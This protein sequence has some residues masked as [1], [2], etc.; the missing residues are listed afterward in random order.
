MDSTSFFENDENI[1]QYPVLINK[2]HVKPTGNGILDNLTF[3]VKD[4]I[5]IKNLPIF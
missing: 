2:I 1:S 4:V 3:A 5:D